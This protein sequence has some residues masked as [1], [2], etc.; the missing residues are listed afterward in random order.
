MWII[1][2]IIALLA[3]IVL[4]FHITLE[5]NTIE[6]AVSDLTEKLRKHYES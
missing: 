3:T 1:L 5:M 6:K 4:M 2:L